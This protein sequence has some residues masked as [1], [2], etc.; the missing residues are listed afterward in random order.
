MF[1]VWRKIARG[2]VILSL[3]CVLNGCGFQKTH[4]RT[5]LQELPVPVEIKPETDTVVKKTPSE[6]KP[7]SPTSEPGFYI[8]MVRWPW[9]TLSTISQWYTDSW[10][11]W[12]ILSK[13]NPSLHPNRIEIGDN[14]FIPEALMKSRKPMPISFLSSSVR[15]K[16]VQSFPSKKSSI[17]S[18]TVGLF[19]PMDTDQPSIESHRVELFGPIENNR[20]S[21]NSDT[22]ELFKPIE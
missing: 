5:T 18:D 6:V 7:P 10:K 11:N 15:K 17:E 3:L 20:V 16:S 14:I 13:A 19:G 8:H 1:T 21:K 22:I 2:L 9:E 4:S 12:K